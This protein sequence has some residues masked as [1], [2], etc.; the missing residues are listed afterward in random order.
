MCGWNR[1]YALIS[2]W[3]VGILDA[4]FDFLLRVEWVLNWTKLNCTMGEPWI[5]VPLCPLSWWV[6]SW[7]YSNLDKCRA[8]RNK[9]MTALRVPFFPFSFLVCPFGSISP[10]IQDRLLYLSFWYFVIL[11]QRLLKRGVLRRGWLIA[12]YW[13][14]VLIWNDWFEMTARWKGLHEKGPGGLLLYNN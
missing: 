2:P 1:I 4:R 9:K 13:F 12:L 7:C 10:P 5:P 11:K 14:D 3:R 6:V 8:K